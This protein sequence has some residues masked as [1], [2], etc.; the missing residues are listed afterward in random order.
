[1]ARLKLLKDG[2]ELQSVDLAALGKPSL[3]VGRSPE[4]DFKIDDRAVGREHAVFLINSKG[5]IVQKRSKFGKLSINGAETNEGA[6]KPGDVVSIADY[7]MRLEEDTVVAVAAPAPSRDI[8]EFDHDLHAMPAIEEAHDFQAVSEVAVQEQEPAQIQIDS[9]SPSMNGIAVEQA[10]LPAASEISQQPTLGAIES[11]LGAINGVAEATVGSNQSSDDSG[12]RTAMISN[13]KI[14]TKLVFKP[15]EANLEELVIKRAEIAIGRGSTCDVILSDKKSS[16]KHLVIKKVGMNFVAQDQ[17]SAN[18]TYVNGVKITEQE[19]AGDD[20]IRIGE[21]EFVFK[22]V[23]QEYFDNEQEYAQVSAEA[24]STP[25]LVS[26]SSVSNT[27]NSNQNIPATQD[28]SEGVPLMLDP[29]AQAQSGVSGSAIPGL[30]AGGPKKKETLV[31]KFKR[32]PP[33][34]K[35]IILGVVAML[36]MF[37]LEEPPKSKPKQAAGPVQKVDPSFDSLPQERKQFVVNTYTLAFDYYK[38]KEYERAIYEVEKILQILPSGY[39]DAKDIKSY[40]QKA[41]EIIKAQEEEK[42]RKEAEEKLRV[43]ISE[44]V[45]RAEKLVLDGNYD[46][47]KIVFS[48]IFERDPENPTVMRLKQQIE[49]REGKLR[50]D[51]ESRRER[52]FKKKMLE[53]TIRQARDMLKAGRYY[54][55][56]DKLAD[57]PVIFADDQ[58]LLAQ[59]KAIIEQAREMLKEKVAPHLAAAKTAMDADDFSTARLEYEKALKIDYKNAS[60]KAGIESIKKIMHTR[61][62]RIYTDAIIAEGLSDYKVARAKFKDCLDQ[63]VPGDIYHG[64]CTRKFKRLELIDR[65]TASV[66]G[67]GDGASSDPQKPTLP[68]ETE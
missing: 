1:M 18:G 34:R 61:S 50:S 58:K 16:R 31:D 66:N 22:A 52:E 48:Q 62:K 47:A 32:Q 65:S 23:S 24:Q 63:A 9:T 10:A 29:A 4:S 56:I 45:T 36:A 33:L 17:G 19:L 59:A 39:K 13:A 30:G 2:V 41:I 12:E 54:E 3:V 27:F 11:E 20:V 51:E 43:E 60:A 53:T 40:A 8:V 38:N 14:M 55:T 21:T 64:R 28:F 25:E 6:V 7:L 44:L 57:A 15:G 35:L 46:D 67:N 68:E 37:M 42:R 5:V 26:M 49:E